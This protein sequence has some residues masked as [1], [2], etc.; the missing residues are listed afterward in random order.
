MKVSRRAIRNIVIGIFAG[1]GLFFLISDGAIVL[2]GGLIAKLQ[3]T[4]EQIYE[5]TREECFQRS[6]FSDREAYYN[7]YDIGHDWGFG[8]GYWKLWDK[9]HDKPFG[10][11]TSPLPKYASKAFYDGYEI[12]YEEGERFFYEEKA[13][14]DRQS[15][16]RR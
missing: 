11:S 6:S 14:L 13:A 15:E 2:I 7:D 4:A 16:P 10:Y 5:Q 9:E 1:A 8:N 3:P 12:G